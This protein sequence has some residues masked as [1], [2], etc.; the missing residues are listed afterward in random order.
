M[1]CSSCGSNQYV[2]KTGKCTPC[3][4]QQL[5]SLAV[6][7]GGFQAIYAGEN[8]ISVEGT[9]SPRA[10]LDLPRATNLRGIIMSDFQR[11]EAQAI[12]EEFA[13]Q[14]NEAGLV[15]DKWY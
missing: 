13:R 6:K 1:I 9:A 2:Q 8:N 11:R 15:L 5:E 10:M 7:N 4:Q 3:I 12:G 14:A